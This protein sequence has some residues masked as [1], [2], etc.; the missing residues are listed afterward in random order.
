[1]RP[2]LWGMLYSVLLRVA[3]VIVA[4]VVL[5]PYLALKGGDTAKSVEKFRPKIESVVDSEALKNPLY[6]LL[7]LT[8]VSFVVAGFR[9]ELWRAGVLAGLIGLAPSL[10]SGRKGQVFAVAIAAAVFGLGHLPQ[11]A[12]GV[13][14]TGALGFGLGLIIVWRRSVW[15]AVLAHGFFDATTF[16]GLYLIVRFFPE[17]LRGLGVSG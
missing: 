10:F 7:T 4:S 8:G 2:I 11:G 5:V 1:V 12:G 16:A 9:E 15:E 17:A 13:F 14:L 3:I 6:L